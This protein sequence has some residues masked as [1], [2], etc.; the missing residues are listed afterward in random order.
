[1]YNSKQSDQLHAL[2]ALSQE[3]KPK[4]SNGGVNAVERRQISAPIIEHMAC[5]YTD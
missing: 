2:A 3:A 4:S 1:M 5:N